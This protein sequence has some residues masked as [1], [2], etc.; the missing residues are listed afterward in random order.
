MSVERSIYGQSR[1]ASAQSTCLQTQRKRLRKGPSHTREAER[2]EKNAGDLTI[3]GSNDPVVEN[4][5]VKKTA[6]K[7][8]TLKRARREG[9]KEAYEVVGLD[10]W[11]Y[12]IIPQAIYSCKWMFAVDCRGRDQAVKVAL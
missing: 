7:E 1:R 12:E 10:V 5:T 4:C 8:G 3:A 9:L 6:V 11:R 2:L